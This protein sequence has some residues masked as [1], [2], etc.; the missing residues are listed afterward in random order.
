MGEV[1]RQ[2]LGCTRP[3]AIGIGI[4]RSALHGTIS[5][6][7]CSSSRHAVPS[8]LLCAC[9]DQ[10][11]MHLGRHCS[12]GKL[13]RV[14]VHVWILPADS[15]LDDTVPLITQHCE[16]SRCLPAGVCHVD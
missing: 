4:D 15:F 10:N 13:P 9:F 5:S 16:I 6:L 2:E 8:M 14:L 1:G 12:P 3:H 7:R 11:C